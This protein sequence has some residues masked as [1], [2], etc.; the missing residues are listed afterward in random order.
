M[1]TV[2]WWLKR[3][4][5]L[6]IVPA[7]NEEGSIDAVV[8]EIQNLGICDVL[9]IDDGSI[10]RTAIIVEQKG[11]LVLRL[12]FNLGIGGAVQAGLK[13]ALELDYAYVIRMDGDGQHWVEDVD[14]LLQVVKLGKADVAIGSRFI[15]G[16]QTYTP[17]WNRGIGIRWFAALIS[18]ITHKPAYD[19]TSG[20]QS[21]NRRAIRI[22]AESYPQDYP[23][24]EA[25]VLLHKTGLRVLEIPVRMK[26]RS[27]G[28][29]SINYH[30]AIYYM[31]KVTLATF[32]AAL[33]QAPH[34]Y[35]QEEQ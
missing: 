13:Y 33:R 15:P 26:S 10:D 5:I 28:I 16:H 24:V 1:E 18:M 2:N 19:T 32:L 8:T 3:D 12:P 34:Q 25:R 11:A 7:F 30:Q 20:M 35:F 31:L 21:F 22:L 4:Q 6:A 14:K 23:E 27:T 17:P 9:V 29:S